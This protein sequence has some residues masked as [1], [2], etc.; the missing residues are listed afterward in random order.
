MLGDLGTDDGVISR[1]ASCRKR[2]CIRAAKHLSEFSVEGVVNS[3]CVGMHN[4]DV[5]AGFR[6][7]LLGEFY[8]VILAC[9]HKVNLRLSAGMFTMRRVLKKQ[10][11]HLRQC[12]RE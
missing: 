8:F 1:P 10:F 6:V 9:Q 4:N 7:N 11:R 5:L 2:R 3:G 12:G